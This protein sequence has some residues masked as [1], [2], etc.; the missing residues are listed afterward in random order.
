MLGDFQVGEG[1]EEQNAIQQWTFKHNE[2][3]GFQGGSV[4]KNPPANAGDARDLGLTVRGV[5]K[6]SDMTEHAYMFVN[7]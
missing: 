1:E 2:Q 5:T 6:E 7:K 3:F 4:I